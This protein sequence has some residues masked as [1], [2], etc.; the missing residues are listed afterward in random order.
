MSVSC[1][2]GDAKII[3]GYRLRACH[4]IHTAGLVWRGGIDG[5]DNPLASCDRRV[6]KFGREHGLRFARFSGELH[7]RSTDIRGGAAAIAVTTVAGTRAVFER[8]VFCCFSESSAAVHTSASAKIGAKVVSH[9][10]YVAFQMAEVAIPGNLFA[11]ILRVIAELR[12]AASC[13]DSVMRSVSRIASKTRG[14]VR[15]NDGQI[16]RSA[17]PRN[18]PTLFAN[19]SAAIRACK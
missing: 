14:K 6:L 15:L 12:R 10:R 4:V 19:V 16:Q 5:E 2:T 17:R 9:G 11:D 3:S 7:G 8:I 18:V 1:A 13:I